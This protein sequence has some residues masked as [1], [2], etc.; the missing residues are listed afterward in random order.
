MNI[1]YGVDKRYYLG[2]ELSIYSLLKH[3][4]KLNKDKNIKN[5]MKKY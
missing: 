4:K 1:L 3:N 2:A 5:N